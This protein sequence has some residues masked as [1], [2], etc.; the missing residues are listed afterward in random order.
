M[1]PD[2]ADAHTVT[3]VRDDDGLLVA[4]G[5]E[6][7]DRDPA[8]GRITG[9]TVGDVST[10]ITSTPFG[11]TESIRTVAA[12]TAVY[13][14]DHTYDDLGRL[15]TRTETVQGTTTE[16]SYD[17]DGAGRLTSVEQDGVIRS[18]RYDANGNR[19]EGPM[20]S[21][22][23]DDQ[24][25]IL[26]EGSRSFTHDEAG[27]VVTVTTPT[28]ATTFDYDVDGVLRD[29]SADGVD[30][31]FAGD[32]LSRRTGRAPTDDPAQARSWTYRCGS[33]VAW[34][35]RSPVWCASAPATTTPPSAASPPA[36]RSCSPEVKQTCTSTPAPTRSTVPIPPEPA[37][38]SH[39]RAAAAASGR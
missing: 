8:T 13:A 10:T 26:Q 18:Y 23:F 17:Y 2:S 27:D 30:V 19:I 6:A 31:T 14:A 36:T 1:D 38:R 20:G 5:D 39:P 15:A 33:R 16:W 34:A 4:V 29:V 3:Y 25:R 9:L 11:E 35:T 12:G 37:R 21:A 32:A 22:F 28:T 24:D 7:I